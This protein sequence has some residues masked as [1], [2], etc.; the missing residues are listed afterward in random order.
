MVAVEVSKRGIGNAKQRNFSRATGKVL[1]RAE[2]SKQ[3]GFGRS[4]HVSIRAG[5]NRYLTSEKIGKTFCS[6]TFLS[7]FYL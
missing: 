5:I 2:A 7:I 6:N 3:Q 1:S 4:A